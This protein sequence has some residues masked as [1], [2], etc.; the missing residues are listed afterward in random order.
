M[1]V[2]REDLVGPL[3]NGRFWTDLDSRFR[4][5]AR[6]AAGFAHPHVVRVYDF[7]VDRDRRAFL[8]MEL[9]EGETLRQR[10]ESGVPFVGPEGAADPPRPVRRAHHC[11]QPRV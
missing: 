6:S 4:H 9:L 3:F 11:A 2:I 8:V 1:K 7:G 5:E 10:L